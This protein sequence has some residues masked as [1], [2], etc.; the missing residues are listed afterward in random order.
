M[1][2]SIFITAAV[3]ACTAAG[4]AGAILGVGAELGLP[5]SDANFQWA[6]WRGAGM[7]GLGA[8]LA[9]TYICLGKGYRP[10]WALVLWVAATALGA[11]AGTWIYV[12]SNLG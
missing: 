12:V 10:W 9:A 3:V 6:T 8:V 7:G 5:L 2:R 1:G 4:V 11:C